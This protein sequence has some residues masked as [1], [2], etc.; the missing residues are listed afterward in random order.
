MTI[1]PLFILFIP[2]SILLNDFI[3][4]NILHGTG[5]N[6]RRLDIAGGYALKMFFYFIIV[7]L[8]DL[9][10][11]RDLAKKDELDDLKDFE[12]DFYDF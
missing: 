11:I 4:D 7:F 2:L 9:L 12:D 1:L 5:N 8:L 10:C 3:I 6:V